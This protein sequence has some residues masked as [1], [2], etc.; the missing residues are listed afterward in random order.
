MPAAYTQGFVHG[1]DEYGACRKLANSTELT[2]QGNRMLDTIL[3]AVRFNPY[4]RTSVRTH[5]GPHYGPIRVH[6]FMYPTE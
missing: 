6:D 2:N 3:L 1:M 4:F 5:L